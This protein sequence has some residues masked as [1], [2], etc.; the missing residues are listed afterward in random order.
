MLIKLMGNGEAAN[1]VYE[2]LNSNRDKNSK[3]CGMMN[4]EREREREKKG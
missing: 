1:I 3:N 4:E 2:T